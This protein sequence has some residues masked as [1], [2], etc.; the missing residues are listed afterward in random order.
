MEFTNPAVAEKY[1]MVNGDRQIDIPG[2]YKGPLSEVHDPAIIDGMIS[3]KS[4]LVTLKP[5]GKSAGGN[6]NG[7]TAPA[8]AGSQDKKN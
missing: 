7:N 2:K 4:N 5:A 6:T 3:R 1:Q 8:A